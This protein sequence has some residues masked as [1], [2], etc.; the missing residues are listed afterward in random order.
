MDTSCTF[1]LPFREITITPFDFA[2][3][4]RLSFFEEPIP[5]SNDAYSSAMVRNVWLRDLF[6]ATSSLKFGYISLV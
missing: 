5:L 4:N 1:C 3:I 2:A 6:G